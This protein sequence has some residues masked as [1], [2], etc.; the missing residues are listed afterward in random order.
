MNVYYCGCGTLYVL[1]QT[2]LTK[3]VVYQLA[4]RDFLIPCKTTAEGKYFMVHIY[5]NYMCLQLE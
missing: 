3:G 4:C 2:T 1:V 5:G